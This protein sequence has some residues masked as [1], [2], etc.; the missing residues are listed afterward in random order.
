MGRTFAVRHARTLIGWLILFAVVV[1]VMLCSLRY[2]DDR[3]HVRVETFH[4]PQ[5]A[6]LHSIEAAVE[7][8]GNES[9]GYPSSEANDVTGTPYCGAMKLAEATMGQDSMGVHRYSAFRADGRD[10]IDLAPLYT[11][12]TLRAR[13]GPFLAT[14]SARVFRL[15]DV[16]GKGKTGPFPENALVLCDTYVCKR[17]NGKKVGM[18]ILYYRAKSSGTK[19]DPNNPDDPQNIYDYRDNLALI[20]LG[21]PGDPNAVHPLAGPKRFYL[22]TQ[23]HMIMGT[24]RPYRDDSYI[25]LSAG[26]DGLY[27]TADDI[28][29]FEWRYRER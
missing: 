27:G 4:V 5:K 1:L 26:Y 20:N 8:F 21:V 6:Q 10:R 14:E 7:L 9:G 23:N 16:Y 28:F 15:V 3:L 25:L 29:N 22:N 18:P 19:H 2:L 24:P 17:P 11:R 12:D 13:L